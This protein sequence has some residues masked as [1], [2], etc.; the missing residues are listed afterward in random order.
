MALGHPLLP[1][2]DYGDGDSEVVLWGVDPGIGRL[3]FGIGAS[4]NTSFALV[5]GVWEVASQDFDECGK[6]PEGIMQA[7]VGF[8]YSDPPFVATQCC[9]NGAQKPF[10]SWY[11]DSGMSQA[12]TELFKL[13]AWNCCLSSHLV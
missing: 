11:S 9:I 13:F 12:S 7:L 5:G 2:G 3:Q 8:F 4:A 6:I 1:G 10:S